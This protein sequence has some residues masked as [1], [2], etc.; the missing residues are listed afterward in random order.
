MLD[1]IKVQLPKKRIIKEKRNGKTY[2]F[3]VLK[4]YR[5]NKNQ[6]TNK[7]VSIGRLDDETN[8]LIPNDTF[9]KYFDCKINVEFIG[10]KHGK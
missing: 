2:V 9:F 3:Y 10:E 5:N 1:I 4:S 6:P 7:R 8:M